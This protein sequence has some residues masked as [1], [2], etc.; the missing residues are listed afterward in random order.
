[1]DAQ[2]EARV[3]EC[4]SG[5]EQG[6]SI[7][8]ILARYPEDVA[9]LRPIL[10]AAAALYELRMEPSEAMKMKSRKDFLA[11]AESLRSKP[12]RKAFGFVPRFAAGI[13]A[14]AVALGVLGTGAVAASGSA[15]PGDPLY[16]IKRTVE[17]V[18]LNLTGSSQR[19]ALLQ[20]FEQRRRDEASKLLDAGRES[21]VEFTGAIESIQPG[22][23]IVS[24][25]VV[26]LDSQTQIVGTPQISRTAEVQGITGPHGLRA[27][28]IMI[29]ASGEAVP[30]PTPEPTDTPEPT[31]TPTAPAAMPTD[32]RE[33]T[34][35]ARPTARPRPAATQT[36][37]PTATPQP[38]E[39]EFAGTVD[40][41]GT[42]LWTIDGAAVAVNTDTEI[43]GP[44]NVGQR[45]KVQALRSADGQLIARRIE[46]VD[47][48]GGNQSGNGGGSPD[49]NQNSND[50][51]NPNQNGNDN[52]NS[53][54]DSNDNGGNSNQNSHDDHS[55]N[56][57]L[58]GNINSNGS[59][60]GNRN[61]NGE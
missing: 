35:T 58:N 50:N 42:A 29:E 41:M 26:Q 39:F 2:F 13:A 53:N 57:N 5:L 59:H 33:P 12:S 38:T 22:A 37:Q 54:P 6:E 11:Q 1:M 49:S 9:E 34:E 8:Q 47:G 27:T 7:E 46:L 51:T 28:S 14:V 18:Q 15:M 61:V 24:G 36:L 43:H 23:W 52:T 4:L 30:T 19:D 55:G 16:G 17:N 48:G 45:V 25:L 40:S 44:I 3:I 32:Q 21:E 31:R 10:A 20:Q 60:D 56:G